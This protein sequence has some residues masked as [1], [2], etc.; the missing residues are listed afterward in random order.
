M[1]LLK[2]NRTRE[3]RLA[4]LSLLAAASLLQ[5]ASHQTE[6]S[7]LGKLRGRRRLAGVVLCCVQETL[8]HRDD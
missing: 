5:L 4:L 2:I 3:M 8:I 7:S 6:A 1:L